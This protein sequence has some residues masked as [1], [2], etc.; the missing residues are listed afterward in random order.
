MSNN[1]T[2]SSLILLTAGIFAMSAPVSASEMDGRIEET[3][4]RTYVYKT[5]LKDDQVSIVSKDGV[6]TLAGSVAVP[7]HKALAQETASSLTGVVRVDN[8]LLTMDAA[9]SGNLDAWIGHKV[10]MTLF[11][12]RNVSSSKTKVTVKAG[13]VTLT[14][15]ASSAG[16]RDLTTEYAKDIEG[17][18]EVRND[19]QVVAVTE[20]AVRTMGEKVDDASITSQVRFALMAHRSSNALKIKVEV[21]N[22]DVVLT[23]IANNEAEKTLVTKLVTDIQGVNSV[24]N[25]M[26][27][28]QVLTK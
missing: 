26:T 1:I 12:H 2:Y 6:V 17:V 27:I 16:Q 20:P 7:S 19:M 3:F 28:G 21:R 15:D 8:Q 24:N 4:K 13:V 10:T 23:G 14:G 5:Y 9:A 22:G 11:L 25:Q 18:K